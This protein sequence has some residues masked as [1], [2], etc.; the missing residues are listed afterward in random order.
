METDKNRYSNAKVYKLVCCDLTYYGSTIQP[1]YKR[2]SDHKMKF[3]LWKNDKYHFVSS[4]ILLEVGEP[5]IILVES[6]RCK[7]K[8]ELHARERFYIENNE[9]VNKQI[10]NRNKTEYMKQYQQEKK[11]KIKEFKTEYYKK[12]HHC[13]LCQK[14]ISLNNKSHHEKSKL[15]LARIESSASI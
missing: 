15:H 12:R 9:C 7:N 1:L 13:D 10:P 6:L 3:Q 4:F 11:E 5:D 2:K 14:D 8:E